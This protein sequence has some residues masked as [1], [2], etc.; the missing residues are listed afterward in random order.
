MPMVERANDAVFIIAEAGVNHDGDPERAAALVDAAAEAGADAVKFQTFHADRLATADAPKAAYQSRADGANQLE[1]LRALELDADAH[2]MLARQCSD[3]N[4]IF[5]SSPFDV[6]SLAFLVDEIGVD[7]L[8]IGSGE[9]T[10]GP[11]LLAAA[12]SGRKVILSTGMST[13]DEVRDA[14]EILAFG[15]DSGDVT[16]TSTARENITD[17]AILKD[18]VT[19]LHCTSQYPAPMK[20][21][22]LRAMATLRDAFGLRVGFSDHTPGATAAIAAVALGAMVIEKHFTLDRS[23]QGPDHAASLEPDELASMIAYIRDV[24]A[25]L[26]SGEKTPAASERETRI[27]ARKSL[28]ALR[29]V[30]AGETFTVENLGVKRSGGGQSPMGYWDRLGCIAKRDYAVDE[31]IE[32]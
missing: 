15:Y 11:L 10:N 26:G 19:L 22:N 31:I 1:M 27:I 23:A 2:R 3:Q 9:I 20:D 29:P 25:A 8:K 18:K 30:R 4:I 21:T 13:L 14:L 12:Q 6:E 16:P 5:L 32:P 7:S 28:V 24:E 17:L